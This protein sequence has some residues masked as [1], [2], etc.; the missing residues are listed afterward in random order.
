M[1]PAMVRIITTA[2]NKADQFFSCRW[3][4]EK[5]VGGKYPSQERLVRFSESTVQLNAS[6]VLA[7]PELKSSFNCIKEFGVE[8]KEIF[9]SQRISM[10]KLELVADEVLK[11]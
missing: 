2:V 9:S 4:M 5:H 8:L 6:E 1:F 3:S 7:S 11:N 10:S